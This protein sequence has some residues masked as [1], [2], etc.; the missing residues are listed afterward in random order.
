M[1]NMAKAVLGETGKL[2]LV[3]E[4]K[5]RVHAATSLVPGTDL[6]CVARRGKIQKSAAVFWFRE[7]AQ[8]LVEL[9]LTPLT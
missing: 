5:H 3:L 6:A 4:L 8:S 2:L 7:L 1:M 9:M